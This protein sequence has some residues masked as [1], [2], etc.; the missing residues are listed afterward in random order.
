V[1]RQGPPSAGKLAE[2]ESE[3]AAFEV[4]LDAH[5][6][7]VRLSFAIARHGGSK[8]QRKLAPHVVLGLRMRVLLSNAP[9]L[10]LWNW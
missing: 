9:D 3:V 5:R 8:L 10:P 7:S 6:T 2:L 4:K 1:L